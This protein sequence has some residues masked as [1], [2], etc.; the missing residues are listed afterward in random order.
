MCPCM[1]FSKWFDDDD[2]DDDDHHHHHHH[3]H[4]INYVCCN[5]AHNMAINF[6]VTWF[7]H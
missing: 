7:T 5:M 6:K 3:P 2:D 1:N 4:K